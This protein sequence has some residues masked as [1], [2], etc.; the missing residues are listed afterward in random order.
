MLEIKN[1]NVFY[2]GIPALKNLSMFVKEGEFIVVIG[3]NG[4]G[5]T[6][7]LNCIA[8][9]VKAFSGKIFFMDKEIQDLSVHQ[10]V[11]L[12]IALIPEGRK[13]FPYLTVTENL[14]MGA[15]CRQD[16]WNKRFELL[17]EI[18]NMFPILAQRRNSFAKTLSGGEQQL[19]AIARV[20]MMSPKLILIDEPS[21]GLMPKILK[22]LS[23]V[24]KYLH[25]EEKKTIILAEQNA[26]LA[27][28]IAERGYVLRRGE[29]YLEGNSDDL[30]KD[31]RIQSAYLGV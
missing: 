11:K 1:L 17:E 9:L 19:L 4:A 13:L 5:K 8:G 7:L 26:R 3:A 24:F 21:T 23:D 18:F 31:S 10:R 30:L 22:Q 29:I 2:G 6:T 15:S 14:L 25:S 20:L 12:G 28:K 27:L 16:L